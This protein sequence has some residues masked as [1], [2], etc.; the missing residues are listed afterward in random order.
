MVPLDAKWSDVGSWSALQEA[1]PDLGVD[2]AIDASDMA[3]YANGQ[4]FVRQGGPERARYSDPNASWGHRSAV[5]TRSGGGFYGYNAIVGSK[6][7]AARGRTDGRPPGPVA[8]CSGRRAIHP[9]PRRRV[10][11]A[12][13][14]IASANAA[15]RRSVVLSRATLTTA[16]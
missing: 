9:T 6:E 8:M 2:V 14:S 11:S 10:A 1:I 5:S 7:E 15:V 3:A 4:R 16:S 12:T 13:R